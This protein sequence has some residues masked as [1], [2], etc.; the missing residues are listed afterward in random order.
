MHMCERVRRTHLV[1]YHDPFHDHCQDI[2]SLSNPVLGPVTP[3][4]YI[5]VFQ[6]FAEYILLFCCIVL[7]WSECLLFC[8]SSVKVLVIGLLTLKLFKT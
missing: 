4:E 1:H 7:F 8:Y 3:P 5:S 2:D 6:Q